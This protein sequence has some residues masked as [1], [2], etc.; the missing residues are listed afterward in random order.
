MMFSIDGG[1]RSHEYVEGDGDYNYS[2]GDNVAESESRPAITR[3]ACRGR[4]WRIT[5][6][7]SALINADGR[8]ELFVDYM[9]VL[10]PFN[11]STAASGQLQEDLHLLATAGTTTVQRR[12]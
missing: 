10:G 4:R 6:I 1:A 7:R 11:P 12:A 5:R 3:C 8:Q 9:T 2:H